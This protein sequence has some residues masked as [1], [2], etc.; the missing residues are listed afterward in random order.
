ME[1]LT[2]AEGGRLQC[3]LCHQVIQQHLGELGWGGRLQC[4][5]CHQGGGSSFRRI[6]A[7][8]S[9]PG[10]L[11]GSPMCAVPARP[12][13]QREVHSCQR[14][15]LISARRGLRTRRRGTVKPLR[16]FLSKTISQI[17]FVQ[18]LYF[19]FFGRALSFGLTQNPHSLSVGFVSNLSSCSQHVIRARRSKH[20]VP[21]KSSINH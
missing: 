5:L 11:P 9:P 8:T 6:L 14:R 7:P 12:W 16:G 1:R 17:S 21:K 18:C 19:H 2:A 4:N 13:E 10:V 15:R 3:S 20:V